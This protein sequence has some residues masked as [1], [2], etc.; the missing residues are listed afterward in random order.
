MRETNRKLWDE[1][2]RL[3]NEQPI[4]GVI[5]TEGSAE[6]AIKHLAKKRA[7]LGLIKKL[8]CAIIAQKG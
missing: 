3:D 8:R 4:A 5:I 2:V 1:L 7:P 6:M